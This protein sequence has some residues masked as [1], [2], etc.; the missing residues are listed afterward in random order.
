MGLPV[1]FEN[2]HCSSDVPKNIAALRLHLDHSQ[3]WATPFLMSAET[4]V[5]SKK[6][7]FFMDAL[8]IRAWDKF[9]VPND[10]SVSRLSVRMECMNDV[11]LAATRLM[12]APFKSAPL[13]QV[14]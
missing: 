6:W 4:N 2:V 12:D 14:L 3:S 11:C 13:K 5:E 1:L 8:S 7:T 9:V 10:E